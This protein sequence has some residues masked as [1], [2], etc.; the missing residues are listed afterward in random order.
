MRRRTAGKVLLLLFVLG[1]AGCGSGRI[2][3]TGTVLYE[4]G[5]PLE[6]GTV[7][8]EA[9]INGTIVAVQGNVRPDGSFEWGTERAG[10]GAFPGNYRVI[11]V[12]RALGDGEIAEGK[13]PAVDKRFT[14]YETSGLTFEVK[15]GNNRLDIKVTRPAV[16]KGK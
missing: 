1:V 2:P 8:G 6:E 14:S 16:R 12:P 7:V 9:E 4:D 5:S 10:D 3:V 11:V 13:Q 15:P